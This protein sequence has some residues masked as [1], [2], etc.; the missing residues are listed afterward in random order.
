MQMNKTP[1]SISTKAEAKRLF[2]EGYALA[3]QTKKRIKPWEKIFNLWR[4]AAMAGHRRAQFYLGTCYDFGNGVDKDV[5]E[6]FEWYMKA[7]EKG[8]KEAQFNIGF[9]YHKRV[10]PAG[11][12]KGGS[13]L[14]S[15]C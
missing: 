11:L 5:S 13:L 8:H 9:F 7:A 2:E 12:R 3:F 15:C 4:F 6:A 10:S 1:N 14:Y